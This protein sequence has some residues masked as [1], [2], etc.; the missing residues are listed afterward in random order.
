MHSSYETCRLRTYRRPRDPR[1]RRL[2]YADPGP[3]RLRLRRHLDPHG[4]RLGHHV[5]P[6]AH[7]PAT[8]TASGQ[9]I[10]VTGSGYNT[11]QGVYIGLCVV[12]GAQGANKP[13]PCLGGQDES[14]TTGAS[15]WV[16]NTF[17][18]LFA[19][20]SKFGAGGTFSV[21]IYVKATLDDGSVCGADNVGSLEVYDSAK[22]ERTTEPVAL[23]G[24][25]AEAYAGVAVTPGGS[26]VYVTD[27]AESKVLRLDRRTSPKVLRSPADRSAE[28]G[29]EVT[30]VATAEGTPEPTVRWQVS[31]DEG[32]T[33]SAVE[34]A[35]ATSYTFTARAEQDGYRYRAEFTN[36]VGT[37][38]TTPVTLTVTEVDD[39]GDG[40]A[41]GGTE[42]P[43]DTGGNGG[44]TGG[45]GS[46][47]GG[48]GSASGSG[49]GDSGTTTGGAGSTTGGT[50]ASGTTGATTSGG[51]LA[52]T[53]VGALSAAALAAA[54]L[55]TGWA[56]YRRGRSVS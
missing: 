38:R 46:A 16:N 5:Q 7:R 44:T 45:T 43:G 30:F 33:W 53:G 19:N 49:G 34:G 6:V 55:G 22:V 27:Q 26:T 25:R 48:S 3:G 35:T 15:H 31:G 37:T 36:S 2:R 18:G 21:S 41:D 11:G 14:G 20:S 1:R 40:G 32:Q 56:A 17:G 12:D 29:D 8:A 9:T 51:S 13:S 23:P 4:H 50:V 39:G 52:S 54:L 42:G 47:S 10:T 24:N 28:P